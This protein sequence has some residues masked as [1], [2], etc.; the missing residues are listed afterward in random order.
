MNYY[1]KYQIILSLIKHPNISL[2]ILFIIIFRILK[3]NCAMRISENPHVVRINNFNYL[4]TFNKYMIIVLH[5]RS[6]K[7]IL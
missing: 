3:A 6:K 2:S 4:F 7:R 5:N 1:F